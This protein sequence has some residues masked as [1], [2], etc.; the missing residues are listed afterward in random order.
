M[1]K[2]TQK[3]RCQQIYTKT[4]AYP[5]TFAIGTSNNLGGYKNI[6]ASKNLG[7]YT[8]IGVS[9]NLGAW[10]N[11]GAYRNIVVW[12]KLG[13]RQCWRSRKSRRSR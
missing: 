1:Q 6:D 4:L 5:K 2:N 8:N 11:I 13:A 7:R 12:K 3:Y 10:K 9:K